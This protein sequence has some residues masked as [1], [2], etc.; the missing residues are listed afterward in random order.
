MSVRGM[1]LGK[2]MPP[3]RGH[4]HL[5]DFAQAFV[6]ELTVVVGTL[7]AEPIPGALRYR[8]MQELAPRA[9]VLHLED[10]NPQDPSEHPQFWRIWRESLLRI[11]P[12]PPQLVFASEPYGA[13]LATELGA[14]FVPVDPARSS[15]PISATAIRRDPAAQWR[16]VPDCVR[17]YLQKRICV[18]GPEST[19]KSTLARSL[20]ERYG[21][22]LV[23]EFARTWLELGAPRDV[24]PEDMPIIAR[25]QRASEVA[26]ARGGAPLLI[27]DTDA[28]ATAVWSDLL[29]GAR[30]AEVSALADTARFDLTLLCD[31]DV[32]WVD[33]A[34]RYLPENRR[35]AFD[36]F[37]RELRAR[38]RDYV[39]LRGDWHERHAMALAAIE[40]RGLDRSDR[41]R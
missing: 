34:V 13:R 15:V 36:R 12:E 6:D 27:A 28:L 11:L 3:H 24:V 25:G 17:P 16:F 2:F 38:G 10:E 26:L 32:P 1:V 18:F 5:I 29:F 14:R 31:V 8:W 41:S 39:V 33:D 23:P 35:A 40:S 4:L 30:A 7:A 22:T 20:A 37:E 19:G 21:A 9:Q